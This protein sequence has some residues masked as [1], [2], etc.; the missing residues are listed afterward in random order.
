MANNN[1]PRKSAIAKSCGSPIK[2]FLYEHR[3]DLLVGIGLI[4]TGVVLLPL[5]V[6]LLEGLTGKSF[7]QLV[8]SETIVTLI[9]VA[10]FLSGLYVIISTLIK[11]NRMR[12]EA[13]RRSRPVLGLEKKG[14]TSRIAHRPI[15]TE[16][17]TELLADKDKKKD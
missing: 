11:E 8:S 17:T 13:T 4:S 6:G 2:G 7:A 9:E 10:V 12:R 15:V 5:F 14:D 3:N 16:R 1:L